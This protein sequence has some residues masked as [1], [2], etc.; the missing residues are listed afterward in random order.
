MLLQMAL[1]DV[2]RFRVS[3]E[4]PRSFD[5]GTARGCCGQADGSFLGARSRERAFEA[6]FAGAYEENPESSDGLRRRVG[7]FR[8]SWHG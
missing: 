5:G 3:L 6:R 8:S 1:H 2:K 4:P 7:R